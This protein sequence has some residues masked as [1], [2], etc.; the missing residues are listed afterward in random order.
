MSPYVFDADR[1][2]FDVLVMGNSMKG[3]VLVHF[4]SP[5]AGPCMVLMPRLIRLAMEYAGRFLLVMANTEELGQRARGLGVTS[6]PTV[7]FFLRGEVVHTIHG[8][9]PDSTFHEALGR[10]LAGPQDQGRMAALALHQ[11]GRTEAAIEMLARIAVETPEDLEVANDLAK[12]LVLAGRPDEALNLLSSLPPAA[13]ATPAIAALLVHLEL[14]D[15]ANNGPEDAEQLLAA[16]PKHA[17]ARLAIA[18]R[19]LLDDHVENAMENLLEL[20]RTAP[21]F[22]EDIGRRA[23]IALFGMLGGEHELTR[24]YRPRLAE[25]RV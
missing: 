8:A 24:R 1:G 11:S 12:L 18:A 9:E 13:R 23:M 15:A 22:R 7:K 25:L 16:D 5:K 19:A 4:W 3:L 20:S 10:F 17:E 6:V 2:N 14:L 21:V